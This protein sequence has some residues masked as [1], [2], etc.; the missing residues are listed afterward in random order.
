MD[1]QPTRQGSGRGPTPR[2]AL[3]IH[4]PWASLIMAGIKDIENRR[5][6]TKH[7]G[8]LW[9]HAGRAT[10]STASATGA[11]RLLDTDDLPAGM[12]LGLVTVTDV[13]QHHPSQWAEHGYWHW[14]LADPRPLAEPIPFRGSQGLWNFPPG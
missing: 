1:K 5:W 10:D 8:P 14:I 12:V 13:V 11:R 6:S 9:V 7:R 2:K 3:T 4:Q